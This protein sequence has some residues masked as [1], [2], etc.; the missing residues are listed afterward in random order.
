MSLNDNSGR[1]KG[2][3]IIYKDNLVRKKIKESD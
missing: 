2:W 3:F 1:L